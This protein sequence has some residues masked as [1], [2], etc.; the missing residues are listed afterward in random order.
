MASAKT[1][2]TAVMPLIVV[3]RAEAEHGG[4]S[5]DAM[6][7]DLRAQ[8]KPLYKASAKTT[9]LVDVPNLKY[10]MI[11][12]EGRPCTAPAFQSAIEALYGL[13]YTMK[14]TLKQAK[15]ARDFTVLPLEGLWW[16]RDGDFD[17]TKP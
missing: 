15:P 13:T 4:Q 6:K 7:V 17:P 16:S 11:D 1:S 5:E 8:F 12:G 14:F 2:Q 10:L 3:P 9:T